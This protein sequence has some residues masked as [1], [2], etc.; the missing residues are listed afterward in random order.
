MDSYWYD[1]ATGKFTGAGLY[2]FGGEVGQRHQ[3]SLPGY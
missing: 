3:R 2:D 1:V